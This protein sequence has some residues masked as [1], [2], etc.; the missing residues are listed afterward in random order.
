ML[1]RVF[2]AVALLPGTALV[3]VP[4]VILWVFRNTPLAGRPSPPLGPLFWAG[5]LLVLAGLF[6]ITWTVSLFA[7]VGRGTLAPWEPPGRLV[8]RGPYRHVRNPMISG[9]LAALLGE[10]VLFQSWPLLGWFL[11]FFAANALYIPLF[12]EPGLQRRFGGDYLAYKGN[13]PR[14]VP[15]LRPWDIPSGRSERGPRPPSL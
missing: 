4:G 1:L 10:A 12:E 2:R 11:L 8:V 6:L 15:R 14:W 3:V 7:R 13:V 9:V 5:L